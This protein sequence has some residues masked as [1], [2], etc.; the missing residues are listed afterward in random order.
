MSGMESAL[1]SFVWNRAAA[2][3]EYC[4]LPQELDALPLHIEHFSVSI[5][6]D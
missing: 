4:K 3:C 5:S 6:E 2:K 1:K